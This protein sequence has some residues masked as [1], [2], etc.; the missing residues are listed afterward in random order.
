MQEF[1]VILLHQVFFQKIKQKLKN[2]GEVTRADLH[3]LHHKC[4][5]NDKTEVLFVDS[6]G[7]HK[8]KLL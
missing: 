1:G 2:V 8:I 4:Q 7:L 3:L 5:P 6:N